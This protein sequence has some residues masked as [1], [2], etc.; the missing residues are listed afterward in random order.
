VCVCVCVVLCVWCVLE[1]QLQILGYSVVGQ[2]ERRK[3]QVSA[4][5]F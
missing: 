5:F 1:V 3:A 4:V 2:F